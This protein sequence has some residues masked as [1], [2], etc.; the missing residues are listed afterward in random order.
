M[1]RVLHFSHAINPN[2]FIDSLLGRLDRRQFTVSAL[3]GS[4]P[5]GG[6]VRVGLPYDVRCLHLTFARRHYAA[7]ANELARE[8]RRA[9]P[10][11]VHAHHYDAT[12]VAAA[13]VRVL[14][15]PA[16]VISRHYS[17]ALYHL[18]HGVKR[19]VFLAAEA[20]AHRTAARIIVPSRHVEHVLVDRQTVPGRKVTLIPYGL[21]MTAYKQPSPQAVERLRASVKA[22][23]RSLIVTCGRLSPEKGLDY[24]LPAIRALRNERPGFLVVIVGDGPERP[25]LEKMTQELELGDVVTFVGWREDAL[26]WIAAADV[27]V[28]PSLSSEAYAQVLVEG[29][30]F[31]KPLVATPVGS[32]PE[33]I[34]QN[35]RGRLVPIRDSHALMRAILELMQNPALGRALAEA[36]RAYVERM[37]NP[38]EVALKHAR[39]YKDVL[40][41]E[42]HQA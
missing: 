1:I 32:A 8:I 21:D 29:L 16:F 12:L 42:S 19:R 20:F 10:H 26:D 40:N 28:H 27:L 22:N 9:R 5:W 25:L 38:E 30:A 24:L 35:E 2:D 4:P 3:V 7:M 15:V 14:R 18:T 36:G 6:R 37:A 31:L 34:G 11:I 13:V 41:A 23:G 33:I 17:D 39:V